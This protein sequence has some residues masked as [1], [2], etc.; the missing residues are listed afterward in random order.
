VSVATPLAHETWF[1]HH[2]E[3]YPLDWSQLARPSV[4]VGV[5]AVLAV[6]VA[7]R[8]VS[9]RVG[10]PE[11]RPLAPLARLLPWVPRLLAVHLGVSLLLLAANRCVLDPSVVVHAGAGGTLLLVPEAVAGL[12]LVTGYAVPLASYAVIAAGPVLLLLSGLQSL[13]S[14]LVLLG[15]GLFLVALPPQPSRGGRA[16]LDVAQLRA[17]VLALRVGT[18]GTL[19][20]LAVVEKLA[21]PAMAHAMLVEKPVL[22]VLAPLGISPDAFA[23]FAG[24]VEVLFGLLVLSGAAPQVAALAAAVPF[25]STLFLFGGTELIGHLPVYGVLLTLLLLGSSAR[26]APAVRWLPPLRRP[27]D[28][29]ALAR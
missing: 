24:C 11:L 18:A 12:L 21:N 17:A 23:T 22:N 8:A 9:T 10:A 1:V 2:P 14:C 7:W 27:S 13:L 5:A 4:V 16:R 3:D 15:I 28:R 20:T 19:I 6:T 25:T 29:V 26:T